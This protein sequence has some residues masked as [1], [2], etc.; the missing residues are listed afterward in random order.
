MTDTF[1]ENKIP[2]E[3]GQPTPQPSPN[4]ASIVVIEGPERIL[5]LGP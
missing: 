5:R 2:G 1:P 4:I 3:G